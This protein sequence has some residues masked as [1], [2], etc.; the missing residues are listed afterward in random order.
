MHSAAF[1]VELRLHQPE[2]GQQLVQRFYELHHDRSRGREVVMDEEKKFRFFA[3]RFKAHGIDVGLG[4]DL[5]CRG[6]TLTKRLSRF[7]RWVGVD[8]DHGAVDM[9]NRNG[10]PCIPLD[11]S[12]AIDFR[13]GAFDAVCATEVLEHLPY[14]TV[15][16]HEVHRIL[17]KAPGSIFI[18]TVP[19]DYNLHARFAVLRGKRLC[20]DP[21]HL[22]SFTFQDVR[23]LLEHYFEVVEFEP[24]RGTKTRHRWLSPHLF[25]RDVAWF[26]KTPR[27]E[28]DTSAGAPLPR[29]LRKVG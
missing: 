18:G 7:G 11:V 19:I 16:L 25:V 27:S 3:D 12:T 21:T 5:G 20:Y 24:M 1:P 22:R 13:D 29:D 4:L 14:P 15:T 9:A 6:G 28:I 17:V 26:A 23:D 2:R 8:I 10:V